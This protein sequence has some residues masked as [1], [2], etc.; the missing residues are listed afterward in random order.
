MTMGLDEWVV[1]TTASLHRSGLNRAIV[2]S[3]LQKEKVILFLDGLD[4]AD[5]SIRNIIVDK[6]NAFITRYPTISLLVCSRLADYEALVNTSKVKLKLDA[7][8]TINPLTPKQ[9][10]EYL[11]AAQ[12]PNC[13]NCWITMKS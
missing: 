8:V 10:K 4:E 3:W 6:I 5:E 9:I 12:A 1:K 7:A 11:D 2:R 13:R